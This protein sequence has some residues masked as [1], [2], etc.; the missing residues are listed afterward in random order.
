MTSANSSPDAPSSGEI[1]TTRIFDASRGTVFHAFENPQILAQWW[2]PNGFRST[3][4]EFDLRPRG[5]WRLVMHG[6][7]GT[8]YDNVSEFVEIVKPERIVFDHLSRVHRFRMTMIYAEEGAGKTR[9]TWRMTFESS[10]ESEKLRTFIA[11]ANEQNF[12][13]L[14]GL[15]GTLKAKGD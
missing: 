8:D 11:S 7:D 14:A 1:V 10:A 12:D 13:R 15:L 9:L 6:P 2:G 3:I 4:R 5:A